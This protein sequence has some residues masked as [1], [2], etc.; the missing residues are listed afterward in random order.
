MR[1]EFSPAEYLS[2]SDAVRMVAKI[3]EYSDS[4]NEW[5]DVGD[6]LNDAEALDLATK[7]LRQWLCD[8]ELTACTRDLR[9]K[10]IN[11]PEW[12]WT[13]D[14]A[15]LADRSGDEQFRGFQF[16]SPMA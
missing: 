7:K 14:K 8:G 11:V 4:D 15:C 9:G 3:P 2:L 5:L 10:K 13:D 12:T 1:R 16:F 6:H